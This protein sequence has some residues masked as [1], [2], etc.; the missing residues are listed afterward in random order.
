MLKSV[1]LDTFFF[2]LMGVKTVARVYSQRSCVGLAQDVGA[3]LCIGR[4]MFQ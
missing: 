2:F 3:C 4:L 1:S